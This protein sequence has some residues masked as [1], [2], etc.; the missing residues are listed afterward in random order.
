MAALEWPADVLSGMFARGVDERKF[1]RIPAPA[2]DS[3]VRGRSLR[4]GHQFSVELRR[5]YDFDLA[6]RKELIF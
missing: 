2:D 4:Y 3:M 1:R 5:E 6:A